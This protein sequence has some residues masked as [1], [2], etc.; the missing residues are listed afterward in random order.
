[1]RFL[2][3]DLGK[4]KVSKVVDLP[5]PSDIGFYQYGF[6]DVL[7]FMCAEARPHLPNAKHIEAVPTDGLPDLMAHQYVLVYDHSFTGGNV[8]VYP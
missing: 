2:F 1:M 6:K 8:L 5:I 3:K 7:D 4:H